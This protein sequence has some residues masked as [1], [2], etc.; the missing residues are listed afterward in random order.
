[1]KD[2][3]F[4]R[5]NRLKSDL[6]WFH[7]CCG[8]QFHE[9]TRKATSGSEPGNRPHP[10]AHKSG[11]A[12]R[13]S[14]PHPHPSPNKPRRGQQTNPPRPP[15]AGKFWILQTPP[16]GRPRSP[17]GLQP[18]L[19]SQGCD[20]HPSTLSSTT[21]SSSYGSHC[22]VWNQLRYCSVHGTTWDAHLF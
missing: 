6:N 12:R 16:A 3:I 4:L 11:C 8:K 15:G 9:N 1:M 14:G 18:A 19:S 13:T 22:H 21:E 2:Y 17:A 5:F 7:Q 20:I 10:G